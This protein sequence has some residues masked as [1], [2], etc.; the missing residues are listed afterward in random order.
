MYAMGMFYLKTRVA[1]Y[2]LTL[3]QPAKKR[4]KSLE[5]CSTMKNQAIQNLQY[6]ITDETGETVAKIPFKNAL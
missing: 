3:P 2:S 4:W 6:E 1:L 5:M